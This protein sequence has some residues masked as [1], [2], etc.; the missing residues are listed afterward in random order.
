MK[1][2]L[3][4]A[5]VALLS[6]VFALEAFPQ[7]NLY[8]GIQAGYSAQKPSLPSVEFDTNDSFLFGVRAGVKIL[9]V[10]VELNYFQAAH[11]LEL[12]EFVTFEWGGREVD[13]NF[14]GVNVKYMFSLFL[15]HPFI[16]VGY[17]TYKADIEEVDVDKQGGY[18]FGV[19]LELMLGNKFS[20]LGEGKYHHV[21]LDIQE[22][23]LSLGDYT[24][25]VGLNL[26]F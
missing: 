22:E 20:L 5:F 26:Y 6:L 3:I 11:N 7:G 14:I 1:K 12:K 15:V 13:Y 8:L 24:F 19:G 10:A 21:K 4:F 18:N 17:G 2:I 16:T 25:S 23:E 9:M